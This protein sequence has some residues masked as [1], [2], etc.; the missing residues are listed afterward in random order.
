MHEMDQIIWQDFKNKKK[1]FC[2]IV[3]DIPR[4]NVKLVL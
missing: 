1:K 3:L 2:N 4:S